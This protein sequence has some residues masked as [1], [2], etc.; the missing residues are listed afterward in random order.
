MRLVFLGTPE[1]ALPS[2]ERLLAGPDDVVGV[3][4]QPDRPAGRG[5]ALVASPVKRFSLAH[6]LP[7]YQPERLR[8]AE[9]IEELRALRP[10]CLIVA[11]Y[12]Q[13]LPQA[14]LDLP[15][16]GALNLHP[17]SCCATGRAGP[18]LY[19]PTRSP[20]SRHAGRC[21]PRHRPCRQ[22]MPPLRQTTRR[23]PSLP[24]WRPRRG[25]VTRACPLVRGGATPRPQDEAQRRHRQLTVEDRLWLAATGVHARAARPRPAAVAGPPPPGGRLLMLQAIVPRHG[26]GARLV[27]ALRAW[28]GGHRD[29]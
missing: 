15:T 27:V 23:L 5:R 7:V 10:D 22:A 24:N 1:F 12:G 4:T 28:P 6:G 21:R 8:R 29:Q 2:L 14:V 19:L 25:P 11:A 16:R 3:Y 13:I 18:V 17:S 9:A 20:V 26:R